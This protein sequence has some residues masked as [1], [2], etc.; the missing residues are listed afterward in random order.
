MIDHW[1]DF[2]EYT[3]SPYMHLV[4]LTW[5]PSG[6]RSPR[7]KRY[8]QGCGRAGNKYL[9]RPWT[10][11]R[12]WHFRHGQSSGL[13]RLDTS[14]SLTSCA[15]AFE[16][17]PCSRG[18]I[19]FSAA[20]VNLKVLVSFF[21]CKSGGSAATQAIHEEKFNLPIDA[22]HKKLHNL[23]STWLH[24]HLH[25]LAL[26]NV[27]LTCGRFCECSLINHKPFWEHH[28]KPAMFC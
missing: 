7:S 12:Q 14:S 18:E 4:G 11:W 2:T 25:G 10:P 23:P 9:S 28:A 8:N 5:L 26:G 6:S 24:L 21:L 15:V 17:C 22:S 27:P 19:L 3:Y 1:L 16:I 20:D 13:Y